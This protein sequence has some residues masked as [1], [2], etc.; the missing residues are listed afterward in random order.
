[1]KKFMVLLL[2]LLMTAVMFTG[3]G[4]EYKIN[5]SPYDTYNYDEYNHPRISYNHWSRC[6]YA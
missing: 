3:C 5:I 4:A 6:F 1:M 2:V